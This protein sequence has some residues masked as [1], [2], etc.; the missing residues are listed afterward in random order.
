M[1]KNENDEDYTGAGL[2]KCTCG[3]VLFGLFLFL[4]VWAVAFSGPPFV[5]HTDFKFVFFVFCFYK[6]T[7]FK[8]SLHD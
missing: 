7:D 4:M 2:A 6:C 8:S 5:D 3:T 1:W